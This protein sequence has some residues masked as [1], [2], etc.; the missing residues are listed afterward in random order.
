MTPQ[1]GHPGQ[2]SESNNDKLKLFSAFAVRVLKTVLLKQ[3]LFATNI[4]KP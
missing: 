1:W 3:E 2:L 4:Y